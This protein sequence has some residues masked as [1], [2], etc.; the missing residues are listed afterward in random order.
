MPC[1]V[2]QRRFMAQVRCLLSR[3]DPAIKR[4][5]ERETQYS[6]EAISLSGSKSWIGINQS[7]VT[8]YLPLR[9]DLPRMLW[10]YHMDS[11][12]DSAYTRHA[13][14]AQPHW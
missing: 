10:R 8:R 12:Q 4:H 13:D 9:A 1:S 7:A 5:K 2:M 6:L 11:M 14:A 3:A